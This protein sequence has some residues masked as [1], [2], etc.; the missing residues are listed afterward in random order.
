MTPEPGQTTEID[1]L[2]T[3]DSSVVNSYVGI[4]GTSYTL[5]SSAW[6]TASDVTVK[7][8]A[9]RDGFRSLQGH[10]IRITFPTGYGNNY[11]GAWGA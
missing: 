8:Y 10:E 5:P 4:T 6:G 2:R 7:V 1:V 3:S 9:A 11:G